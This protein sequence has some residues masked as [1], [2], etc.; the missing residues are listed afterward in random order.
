MLLPQMV[1]I[2]DKYSHPEKYKQNTLIQLS[3]ATRY[4]EA[5]NT[6]ACYLVRV[7]SL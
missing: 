4:N 7:L 3:V 1:I 6:E 2:V 5:E